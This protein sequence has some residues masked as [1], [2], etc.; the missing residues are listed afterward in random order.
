MIGDSLS[1][2][3]LIGH[4]KL[5]V[6]QNYKWEVNLLNDDIYKV[7]LPSRTDLLWSTYWVKANLPSGLALK[8]EEFTEHRNI[9][10]KCSLPCG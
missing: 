2:E 6:H 4:L 8:F 10:S 1:E 9:L 7:V 3:E 5:L